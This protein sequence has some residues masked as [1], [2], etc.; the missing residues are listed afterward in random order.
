MFDFLSFVLIERM[1][2]SKLWMIPWYLDSRPADKRS[3]INNHYRLC[4]FAFLKVR[5]CDVIGEGNVDDVTSMAKWYIPI[6]G[7][8]L[9][10][11][12]H[13]CSIGLVARSPSLASNAAVLELVVVLDERLL[14]AEVEHELAVVVVVVADARCSRLRCLRGIPVKQ[15][16]ILISAS[17]DILFFN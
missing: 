7:N 4:A 10:Q 2:Q 13:R 17:L 14:V 11:R 5:D 16:I 1:R 6:V 15:M 9:G 8:Q 3:V 12:W